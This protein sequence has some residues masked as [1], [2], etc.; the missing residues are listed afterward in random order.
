MQTIKSTTFSITG[1][2]VLGVFAPVMA[3]AQDQ[4]RGTDNSWVGVITSD[5]ALVRCGANESY[6]PIATAKMGDLVLVNGKR[7]DWLKID[8]VGALFTD[9]VGY[10]KYSSDNVS[11]CLVTGT[12]GNIT[13]DVEVLAKNV[14]SDELYRSWRPILRLHDGDAVWILNTETTEPGTLH[15]EAYI[16]HTIK[17]PKG[18]SGWI[19]TSFVKKATEKQ[20]AL[21]YDESVAS[22][23]AENTTAGGSEQINEVTMVNTGATIVSDVGVEEVPEKLI[24]LS[25][26]E[27]EAAWGKITAEPAMRAEVSPLKD[28]YSELLGNSEDDLVVVQVAGGRIKQLDVWAGLQVQRSRIEKLRSNL[29]KQADDVSE[30]QTIMAMNEEYAIVGKLALSNTFDGRLRPLMYRIQD[31]TSGRTVGYLPANKDFELSGLVGQR[32]GVVGNSAWNPTWRVRVVEGTR[33]DILSPTTAIV[34]PDIQ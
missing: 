30:F 29:G 23:F 16:V 28:L 4:M 31:Q 12:T 2:L 1:A 21:F 11:T 34:T 20:V 27:L 10:V 14:D 17:M 22:V 24:P 8:T 33:F 15:R 32:V 18:G 25:L 5:T 3:G 9:V 19:N 13:G 6:Y 7:Q 26:V